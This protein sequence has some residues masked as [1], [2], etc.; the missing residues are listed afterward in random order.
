MLAVL[1]NLHPRFVYCDLDEP[2]AELRF[3]TEAFDVDKSLEYCFLRDFLGVGLIVHDRH[4]T[5]EDR[6]L[7]WTHELVEGI[8]ITRAD[9]LDE[10]G[11]GRLVSFRHRLRCVRHLLTLLH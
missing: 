8:A 3:A 4:G 9:A 11:L 7:V 10:L 6:T 5:H 1:A 2:G